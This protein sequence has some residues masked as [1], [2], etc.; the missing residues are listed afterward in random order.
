MA[1]KKKNKALE[2]ALQA[3][4]VYLKEHPELEE[5]QKEIDRVMEKCTDTKSRMEA[6]LTWSAANTMKQVDKMKKVANALFETLPEK[7]KEKIRKKKEEENIVDVE[8]E[9]VATH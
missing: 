7:E 6:L 4:D 9:E 1:K 2:N 8:F 3:R 5:Y